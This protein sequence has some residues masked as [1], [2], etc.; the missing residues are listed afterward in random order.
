MKTLPFQRDE[1]R[2][3]VI[4]ECV[5]GGVSVYTRCGYCAHCAGVVVGGRSIPSPQEKVI[6]EMKKGGI[7][8]E[9]LLTAALQFNSLIATGTAILCSDDTGTG[10]QK[11]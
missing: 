4:V 8:D 10:Y 3:R 1:A 7:S 2:N 11:R 6:S 5:S 9:T